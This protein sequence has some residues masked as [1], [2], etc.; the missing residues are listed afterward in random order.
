MAA[1]RF[2]L[3]SLGNP[4]PYYNTLHSAGHHAL[5]NLQKLLGPSQPAFHRGRFGGSSCLASIGPKYVMIQ[6]PAVMNVSGKWVAKAWKE[7]LGARDPADLSLLL[8]H[9]DL[10]EELGFVKTRKW[11]SSHRGHNGVKSVN[12]CLR[13]AD[14]P[15]SEWARICVGIGRPEEREK[16]TV[17]NYVLKPM[18][19]HQWSTLEANAGPGTLECLLAWEEKLAAAAGK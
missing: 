7:T 18:S 8:V 12:A 6:S 15:G 10:E 3:I 16:A 9:D 1:P 13:Q 17:S 2:L 4:E 5:A 19:R 11:K 14:Y